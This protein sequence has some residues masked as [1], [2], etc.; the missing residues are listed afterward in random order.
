[1]D[2]EAKLIDYFLICGLDP[3]IGIEAE[4]NCELV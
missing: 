4:R 1:M 3:E 2:A